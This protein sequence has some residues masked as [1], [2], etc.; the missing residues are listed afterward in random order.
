VLGCRPLLE[1]ETTAGTTGRETGATGPGTPLIT[2]EVAAQTGAEN[3]TTASSSTPTVPRA[4]RPPS[5]PRR[6]W[7]LGPARPPFSTRGR[8]STAVAPA[9]SRPT[10]ARSS[11][12]PGQ[13]EAADPPLAGLI[14][15]RL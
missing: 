15:A 11:A 6:A 4:R 13:A 2:Q 9:I 10:A 8:A 3:A 14:M 1:A 12:T 5:S 7:G